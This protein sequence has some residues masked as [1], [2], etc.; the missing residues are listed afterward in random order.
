MSSYKFM[1]DVVTNA[2]RKRHKVELFLCRDE[3]GGYGIKING[4]ICFRNIPDE[5][6]ELELETESD[7]KIWERYN[8]KPS[9]KT[10]E[11]R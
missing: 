9:Q 7:L 3:M 2:L 6:F 10:G 4:K 11:S 8:P 1:N 5:A